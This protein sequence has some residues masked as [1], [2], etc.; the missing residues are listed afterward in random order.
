MLFLS[1]LSCV[2]VVVFVVGAAVDDVKEANIFAFRMSCFCLQ[3]QIQLHK[4]D[5]QAKWKKYS[6]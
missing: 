6:R 2:V 1:I 5:A 4:D 3:N